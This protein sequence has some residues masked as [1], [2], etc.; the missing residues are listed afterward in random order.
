MRRN[1]MEYELYNYF[2]YDSKILDKKENKGHL[3]SLMKCKFSLMTSQTGSGKTYSLVYL[4]KKHNIKTIILVPKV[5][6]AKHVSEKY[7]IQCVHAKIKQ[8][9]K[10]QNVV[11]SVY[12]SIEKT[13][14]LMDWP[15]DDNVLVVI[16]EAHKLR[17]DVKFRELALRT[18]RSV[19]PC[20]RVLLTTASYTI[21]E[22]MEFERIIHFV[23]SDPTLNY[24]YDNCYLVECKQSL[25]NTL[26]ALI[27]QI[28]RGTKAKR[29]VLAFLNDTTELVSIR[30][31]LERQ[32]KIKVAILC[33]DGNK[34][35][36]RANDIKA[37]ERLV[38]GDVLEGFD[39][40]LCTSVLEESI[41]I[42]NKEHFHCIYCM[43]GQHPCYISLEQFTARL[44]EKHHTCWVLRTKY[45]NVGKENKGYM[46]DI[47]NGYEDAL[48]NLN[49]VNETYELLLEKGFGVDNDKFDECYKGMIDK[50]GAYY[51]DVNEG[52]WA[53][54]KDLYM[55]L[56][57]QEACKQTFRSKTSHNNE[58]SCRVKSY[59]FELINGK[60]LQLGKTQSST[61]KEIRK[62]EREAKREHRETLI[63]SFSELK[64]SEVEIFVDSIGLT[65]IKDE[66]KMLADDTKE[67]M[68]EIR[69][70]KAIMRTLHGVIELGFPIQKTFKKF[71][72][73]LGEIDDYTLEYQWALWNE[74]SHDI[75]FKKL[76]LKS[77]MSS[78]YYKMRKYFGSIRRKLNENDYV[79]ALKIKDA[80]SKVTKSTLSDDDICK[81][82]LYI[83]KMCI[84]WSNGG[85]HKVARLKHT[86]DLETI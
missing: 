6:Q 67:L 7:D 76:D 25:A 5:Q 46:N 62:E 82:L 12:D 45:Q 53:I 34:D 83:Q 78:K 2:E 86:K 36:M 75:V 10:T 42:H 48:K 84:V 57:Y 54:D 35:C 21:L 66:R 17:T 64:D 44:R 50:M 80:N 26:C 15:K 60:S 38:K 47:D 81:A 39:V 55:L 32:F 51:F 70:D 73:N 22:D 69:G 61:Y 58:V 33:G 41:N 56:E 52:R 49:N 24:V 71:N 63:K 65:T 20:V 4:A 37:F 59:K 27:F 29:H 30:T 28:M 19:I 31:Y 74:E 8:L 79:Q 18:I 43:N 13:F 3:L 1:T 85:R 68:K 23:P 11:V 16:D 77:C 72:Y 14:S 9:D 40:Y